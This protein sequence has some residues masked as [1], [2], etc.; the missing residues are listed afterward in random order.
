M[1]ENHLLIIA[2][3]IIVFL[4]GLYYHCGKKRS[5]LTNNDKNEHINDIPKVLIDDNVKSPNTLALYYASWCGACKR[6]KPS[7]EK[8][9]NQ[10]KK[11]INIV[12]YEDG[13]DKEMCRKMNITAYPTIILHKQNGQNI[14]FPDNLPHNEAGLNQFLQENS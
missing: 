11:Y 6:F 1:N 4:I 9:K 12:E 5:N 7:W 2:T 8:F 14:E 3:V 13:T 10:N